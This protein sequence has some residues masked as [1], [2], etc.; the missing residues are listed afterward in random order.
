VLSA[1]PAFVLSQD[2]TLQFYMEFRS[3]RP[4]LSGTTSLTFT[5]FSNP[6]GFASVRAFHHS[7]FRFQRPMPS[8]PALPQRGF[9]LLLFEPLASS[10]RLFAPSFRAGLLI[11]SDSRLRVKRLF[12]TRARLLR[13]LLCCP[14]RLRSASRGAAST[15]LA[16]RCQANFTRYLLFPAQRSSVIAQGCCPPSRTSLNV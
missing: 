9:L 15:C 2:Q 16:L 10:S 5:A 7:L 3:R 1:P 4:G 12:P 6:Y 14:R 8:L 11:L 13:E